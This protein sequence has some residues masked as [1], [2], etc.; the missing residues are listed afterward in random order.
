MNPAPN[1]RAMNLRFARIA[2]KVGMTWVKNGLR[3]SSCSYRL[4]VTHDPARVAT[5]AGNSADMVHGHYKALVSEA[6]GKAWFAVMPATA[7][8]DVLPMPQASAA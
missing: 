8:A 6:E 2:A 1:D 3:H 7:G 5:E 4:A